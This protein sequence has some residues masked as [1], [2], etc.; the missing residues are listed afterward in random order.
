MY[1]VFDGY[2]SIDEVIIPK[3]LDIRGKRY[4]FVRF[5][6]MEDD[7]LFTVKLDNIFIGKR[8]IFVNLPRLSRKGEQVNKEDRVEDELKDLVLDEKEWLSRWFREVCPWKPEDM[9]DSRVN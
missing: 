2:G 6:N 7:R 4:E 8:K 9:D 5:F 1:E 3:K